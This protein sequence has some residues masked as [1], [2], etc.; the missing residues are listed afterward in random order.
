MC[1]DPCILCAKEKS[2]IVW[3]KSRIDPGSDV[4]STVYT[5]IILQPTSSPWWTR[6]VFS[7][8]IADLLIAIQSEVQMYSNLFHS[9]S[10]ISVSAS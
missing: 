5:P 9:G 1:C 6:N 2:I 4:S 8:F 3:A 10:L 7:A